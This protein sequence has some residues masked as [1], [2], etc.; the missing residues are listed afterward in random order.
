MQS[1]GSFHLKVDH[2]FESQAK[3]AN[4][5]TIID[6]LVSPDLLGHFC[7]GIKNTTVCDIELGQGLI[8]GSLDPIQHFGREDVYTAFN[9]GHQLPP[10]YG[11]WQMASQVADTVPD[12]E[13]VSDLRM[14]YVDDIFFLDESSMH[15]R[16]EGHTSRVA[17]QI[18]VSREGGH[19]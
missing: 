15:Q 4:G 2:V 12:K 8:L 7:I 19:G 13:E 5:V 9:P 3:L 11:I 18:R 1:I 17:Y 6:C 10:C 16:H 14:E